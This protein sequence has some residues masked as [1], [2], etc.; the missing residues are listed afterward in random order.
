MAR[1]KLPTGKSLGLVKGD[2]VTTEMGWPGIVRSQVHT[3]SPVVEVFGL[4]HEIGGCYASNLHKIT[5]EE[6]EK[7]LLTVPSGGEKMFSY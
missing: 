1:S 6:F 7:F 2:Y 3:F 4:Y 5:F